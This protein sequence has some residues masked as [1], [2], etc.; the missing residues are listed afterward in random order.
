MDSN[1]IYQGEQLSFFKLFTEKKWKI[2]IPIIQRDYAQGRDSAIN[3]RDNFLNSLL[4]HLQEIKNIDL[5]F[6]YGSISGKMNNIFIPIDGQQRL[7]TLFL[8]HWYLAIKD[9]KFEHF[10]SYME[11]N[12][13]SNFSYETRI[14]TH[15]FCNA[16]VNQKI[17]LSNLIDNDISKTIKDKPWYYEVWNNDP[18]IKAMLNMLNSIHEKFQNCKDLYKLLIC[19]KNP[20]ITFQFLNLDKFSLTDDLYIKMNS[21]GKQLTD[22]ENFKAKLEQD[23]EHIK[24]E[25]HINKMT[26]QEYFSHQIDTEW[27]DLFWN[28]KNQNYTFDNEFMN[29][30]RL[31]ITN[32][33]AVSG[34][35][36]NKINNLQKLRDKNNNNLT[37][38]DY[39]RLSCFDEKFISDLIA[40][41][42][43]LKNG[44]S[45]IRTY[46]KNS[47][48]Y[49]EKS[50]FKSAI[51]NDT[52]YQDKIRFYAFYEYLIIYKST[53]GIEDWI[54]IVYNL[55]E[56]YIY[57]SPEEYVRSI[58]SIDK[59]LPRSNHILK[60]LSNNTNKIV[61]FNQDQIKEERIKANLILKSDEWFNAIQDIE[62]HEYFTGQISFCLNFAGIEK[63]Y[64]QKQNCNWD[65]KTDIEYLN[66]FKN[67]SKKAKAIFSKDGLIE[68]K[69][70]LWHRALFSKGDYL[71]YK[72]S[73]WSF[74]KN[75]KKDRDISWKRLLRNDNEN[76]RNFVKQ[77]FDDPDFKISN[78]EDSLSN[79]IKKY[80]VRDWKFN[81]IKI[82][83]ILNYLGDEKYIRYESE[84]E[85]SLLEKERLNGSHAEYY[86]YAFF[87]QYLKGEIYKPF[88]GTFY[89]YT[90]GS[91]NS[92]CAVI[93]DWNVSGNSYAIDIRFLSEEKSYEIRFFNREKKVIH[94][95]IIAIIE[96]NQ[97]TLSNHYED[98]SYL[99]GFKNEKKVIEFIKNLCNEFQNI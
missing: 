47:F 44:N 88:T 98:K 51:L 14:S 5:D 95:S 2:E 75:K 76:K 15:E 68:L 50:V 8:L 40:I 80:N 92:P 38:L 48:H 13:K 67:Y 12:N 58:Q 46:L 16:L 7:T 93:D 28:Y 86:S 9:E 89:F 97:M 23:I 64:N 91:E 27:A 56:N 20:I 32:H 43:F 42:D 21:R 65:K 57:D 72:K 96:R 3:V 54:R 22:F 37:Y 25:S 4:K 62:N 39:K 49:K 60:Y 1:K 55:T 87:N 24:I 85:I 6:V 36:N 70:H 18:S 77:V 74:L 34:K 83:E 71:I 52:E 35:D 84:Y 78:I 45:E 17:S 81:F 30:I 61:G 99:R 41:L 73:N 82:P 11:S 19:T 69:D 29:F 26:I 94:K 53:K 10:K 33:Y 31:V 79:I 90:S 66:Q 63:Y 59:L